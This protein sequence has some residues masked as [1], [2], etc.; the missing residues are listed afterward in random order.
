MAGIPL[1][2][3][4]MMFYLSQ[5]ASVVSF[6][7]A[8]LTWILGS[9]VVEDALIYIKGRVQTMWTEFWA[10]LSFDPSPPYVDTF[11]KYLLLGIVVIWAPPSP[12][13][14]HVVCTW[15][16]NPSLWVLK[17]DFLMAVSKNLHKSINKLTSNLQKDCTKKG[18]RIFRHRNFR[19]I[20]QMK[21][22]VDSIWFVT[23]WYLMLNNSKNRNLISICL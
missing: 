21:W 7:S 16:L 17:S 15:L 2:V 4:I 22:V 19:Q 18:I 3:L 11:T 20:W 13:L 1:L 12:S 8:F 9:T 23:F 6:Y 14:V 5:H 10:I